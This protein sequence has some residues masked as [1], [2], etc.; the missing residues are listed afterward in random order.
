MNVYQN[1]SMVFVLVLMYAFVMKVG[2]VLL[3]INV[4]F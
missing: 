1:V 3:V 2:L 4:C